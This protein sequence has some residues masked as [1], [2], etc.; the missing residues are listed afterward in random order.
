M[1]NQIVTVAEFRDILLAG[2]A[3]SALESA[4]IFCFQDNQYTVG[5]NWLYMNAVG[6]I[7]L[8]VNKVNFEQATELLESLNEPVEL[9]GHAVEGMLPDSD[10][11]NCGDIDIVPINYKRKFAAIS[12]LV[13][14]PLTY[15]GK[16]Y[17]CMK[18]GHTFK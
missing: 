11:P 8:K 7:K 1:D 6:G 16:H 13:G 18:C 3:Q 10:C 17:R 14:F 4:G 12:L 2:L 15:F 5:V 9:S